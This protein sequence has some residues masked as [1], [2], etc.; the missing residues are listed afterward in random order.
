MEALVELATL[1]NICCYA[2][3]DSRNFSHF[4]P[5]IV[6]FPSPPTPRKLL[7]VGRNE[8]ELRWRSYSIGATFITLSLLDPSPGCSRSPSLTALFSPLSFGL[9]LVRYRQTHRDG[10]TMLAIISR[11]RV[12][13]ELLP[14][15]PDSC[16]VVGSSC[17]DRAG[18][19]Y[20]SYW[21]LH[22]YPYHDLL[23]PPIQHLLLRRLIHTPSSFLTYAL[24]PPPSNSTLHNRSP[25]FAFAGCMMP[26]SMNHTATTTNARHRERMEMGIPLPARVAACSKPQHGYDSLIR[27]RCPHLESID[28]LTLP[29]NRNL[30][31][32]CRLY[33]ETYVVWIETEQYLSGPSFIIMPCPPPLSS[34][35]AAYAGWNRIGSAERG[36]TFEAPLPPRCPTSFASSPYP[37]FHDTLMALHR[38][39]NECTDGIDSTHGLIDSTPTS[40]LP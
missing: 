36:R 5:S 10:M 13:R 15:S 7:S 40:R 2:L 32:G 16:G 11:H 29:R 8:R 24:T 31:P 22:H 18:I 3:S 21:T 35:K 19:E 28:G 27:A 14:G 26:C 4:S 12:C 30:T 6:K 38:P 37:G 33:G 1:A 34:P 20:G 39:P 17:G 25:S 23:L 9:T